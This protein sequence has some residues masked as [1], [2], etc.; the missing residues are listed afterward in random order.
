L[1][2]QNPH[3]LG[4]SLQGKRQ[5][6]LPQGWNMQ[7]NSNTDVILVGLGANLPGPHGS[8]RQTL[9]AAILRLKELGVRVPALSRFWKTR[10]VPVS[11]QPW[12]V[13]AVAEVETDL[14][15]AALLD[16][17]HRVED[18]FGRVRSVVNAPR[19]IDLD[20]L[21]Y[22]RLRLGAP[23]GPIVPHPRLSER[24]FVLL[25]LRD[26]AAEWIHPVTGEDL[27]SMISCLP[28]DQDVIPQS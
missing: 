8:P 14:P 1:P 11:D 20:L 15:P 5:Q 9:E 28:D 12:F 4:I 10:P 27:A 21:A 23:G 7:Q 18:E 2:R 3:G 6:G 19:L 17:L 16:L 24:A 25:P 26:I 22:G 13:N